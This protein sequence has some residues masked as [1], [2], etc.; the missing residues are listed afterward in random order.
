[1][2]KDLCAKLGKLLG[3]VEANSISGP[4]NQER[5]DGLHTKLLLPQ[6]TSAR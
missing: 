5:P 1:M 3:R 4:C 2:D 6:T